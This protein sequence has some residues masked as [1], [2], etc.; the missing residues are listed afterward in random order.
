MQLSANNRT[1]ALYHVNRALQAN[2]CGDVASLQQHAEIVAEFADHP[3][4]ISAYVL[5][6]RALI[7]RAGAA[8]A[9]ERRQLL[10]EASMQMRQAGNHRGEAQTLLV[11]S[12]EVD[13]AQL[14]LEY[15]TQALRAFEECDDQSGI[16]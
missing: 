10:G 2:A 6:L 13:E 14:A 16:A 3:T 7:S 1:K 8:D 11:L 12:S 4:A 9:G 5:L 15:A